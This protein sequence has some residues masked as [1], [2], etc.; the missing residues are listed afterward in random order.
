M[1][2]P[3]TPLRTLARHFHQSVRCLSDKNDKPPNRPE[4]PPEMREKKLQDWEMIDSSSLKPPPQEDPF[5]RTHRI[6]KADIMKLKKYI[7]YM[8]EKDL[9]ENASMW[10]HVLMGEGEI[11][12]E[13]EIFPSHCDVVI[14]GGGAIG[15]SIAYNLKT[16][17]RDGLRIVLLEQDKTYEKASSALSL[18]GLR[19]QFSLEEN[20]LMSLHA[21]DFLRLS[22]R[23][24]GDHVNVNYQPH[25]Y[26]FM[27]SE[28]DA[29][30]L[31]KN[32]T[33]QNRLG[34]KNVLLSRKKLKERFPWLNVDDIALGKF[35]SFIEF[36]KKKN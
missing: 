15:S 28:E 10:K 16:R 11:Y 33:L 7:P 5:A 30:Q 14:V 19:Q 25:G 1:F 2:L 20:I 23:Y 26:L 3:R 17:A 21:A 24:L 9:K 34:A 18:G 12:P 4:L 6:L 22:K 8:N 31:E 13:D 29:E 32:S 35:L 36:K 27:A